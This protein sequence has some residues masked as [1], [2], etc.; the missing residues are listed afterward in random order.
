MDLEH[1]LI[2]FVIST[3]EKELEKRNRARDS[4][5]TGRKS[6][7]RK[8]SENKLNAL[9]NVKWLHV[10]FSDKENGR[11]MIF[12]FLP[13]NMK[14]LAMW[15]CHVHSVLS[16]ENLLYK[17]LTKEFLRRALYFISFLSC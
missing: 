16:H 15:A 4:F 12:V 10:R 5:L 8:E 13:E 9:R 6:K 7:S 1:H 11:M 14:H 2:N 3:V 17:K